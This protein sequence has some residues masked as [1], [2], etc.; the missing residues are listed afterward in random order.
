MAAHKY[1][2]ELGIRSNNNLIGHHPASTLADIRETRRILKQIPHWDPFR[3]TRFRLMAGSPLYEGLSKEERAVP[4]PIRSFRLPSPAARYAIEFS[5]EVPD[6]IKPGPNVVRTWNAFACEYERARARHETQ[7][8]LEVARVAPDALRITDTRDG[9][10][11]CY[12]FS[13]A[14]ARIYDACHCGSKLDEIAQATGLSPQ[15][16]K[17]KLGRFLRL[18]LVLRVDDDYLSLAMRPR[19]ELLCRFFR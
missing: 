8:R 16:V 3:L 7:Q 10:V 6:R 17:A 13:G 5:F 12:D 15:I 19:D 14:A 1:L 18:K 11:L 4:R 2:A 9:K